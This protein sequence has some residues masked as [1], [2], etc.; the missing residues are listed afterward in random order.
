MIPKK[1]LLA[2]T[3]L[4]VLFLRYYYMQP[5]EEEENT[6]KWKQNK[7]LPTPDCFRMASVIAFP[8]GTCTTRLP[9]GSSIPPEEKATEG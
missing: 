2:A 8:W 5:F 3:K 9:C 6:T 1:T 4:L 7:M